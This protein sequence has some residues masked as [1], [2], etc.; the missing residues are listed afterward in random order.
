MR[1][2]DQRSSSNVED[3][4]GGGGFGGG[5]GGGG[6]GFRFGQM[7]FGT[8]VLI[9]IFAVIFRINPL[10][11]LAGGGMPQNAATESGQMGAP[12]DQTG[13]AM[14]K[15]LGSTEDVWGRLFSEG[16]VP[17]APSAYQA[18]TLVLFDGAVS[19][20]C[21]GAT[22]AVGPFYCPADQKLYL[23]TAFFDELARRFNSPGDFAQA[24]V[25][26]HEVGHH[27]QKLTGVSAQAEQARRAMG[28][29]QYNQFSVRMELQADCYAGVWGHYAQEWKNQI[30]PGDIDEALA[31]ANAIGDDALQKSAQGYAVP[32]SFTHGTSAQRVR[33]FRQ[34]FDSGDAR[35]CDTFRTSDL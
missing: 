33:W 19:S 15:I 20:A 2:D 34:G 17:G 16:K 24:Y 25:I 7:S 1:L 21:G 29:T 27:I 14:S 11:L 3:R 30:E 26:A 23:D 9:V 12:T 6:G 8:I 28:K 10:D 35:Q 22:A 5:F 4:R 31:A 18:P 13:Q 32:D